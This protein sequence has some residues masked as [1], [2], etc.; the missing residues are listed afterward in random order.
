[1]AF[2]ADQLRNNGRVVI[3]TE[4]GPRMATDDPPAPPIP[5]RPG[6]AA[7]SAEQWR[8]AVPGPRPAPAATV[9]GVRRFTLSNG[10][11]VYLVEAHR[12]PLVTATLVSR[13]G[14]AADPAGLDGLA[15][16]TAAMVR[17]GT[18]DLSADQLSAEVAGFGGKLT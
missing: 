14:S 5:T 10:M 7:H 18:P 16:V 13:Y 8:T 6:P 11:P 3:D 4:P 15:T 17:Q 9:P 2:A 1:M 12:L